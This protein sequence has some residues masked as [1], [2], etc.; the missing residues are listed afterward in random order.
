MTGGRWLGRGVT[1]AAAV[2][3]LA[4]CGLTRLD[5]VNFRVDDRLEFVGPEARST[6]RAPLT[7]AWTMDDFRIAA[8]GSEPPSDEAGYFAIFV[9]Q[10]PVKPG[11]TLADVAEG[12]DLCEGKPGCPD[13][14]YL[15]DHDVYTT[16]GTSIEIP[17]IPDITG[18]E[19]ELQLHTITIVLMDSSGH[20]IG[21]SAWQLD[22]R[23]PKVG[24]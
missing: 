4:G 2:V 20:R 19:E 24:A 21:E 1:V 8:E 10:T 12:D 14:T 9:D 16:T 17:A 11:H 3:V 7:V 5:E 18:S 22:L 13:K 6:V 15:A 23:M